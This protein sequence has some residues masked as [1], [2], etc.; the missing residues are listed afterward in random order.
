MSLAGPCGERG[1]AV[2]REH[3]AAVQQ[4][5]AVAEV[6]RL[7]HEVGHE[8][9]GDALPAERLDQFPG[10]APRLWIEPGR[11]FVKDREFG[12]SDQR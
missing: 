1:W 10:L 9:H 12:T 8:N 6:L 3:V 4:G 11:Q 7:L 2:D 5:D